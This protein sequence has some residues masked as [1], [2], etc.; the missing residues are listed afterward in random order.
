VPAYRV[1][2]DKKR[3]LKLPKKLLKDSGLAV[4][5]DLV[6]YSDGAGKVVFASRSTA[7]PP[8][9]GQP[10]AGGQQRAATSAAPP[11]AP[12][13]KAPVIKKSAGRAGTTSRPPTRTSGPV[14]KAAVKKSVTKKSVT[15]KTAAKKTAKKAAATGVDG[16]A[17]RSWARANGLAV[18]TRGPIPASVLERYRARSS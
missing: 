6:A 17:V 12:A 3:R 8:G 4:A 10:R 13:K 2:L 9:P 18:S 11:A 14:N 16:R 5:K 15:K 7:P 1:S